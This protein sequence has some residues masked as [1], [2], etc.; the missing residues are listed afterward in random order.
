MARRSVI[1]TQ[2]RLSDGGRGEEASGLGD[3]DVEP[4]DALEAGP[5]W[6]DAALSPVADG[7]LR[8]ADK[9]AELFEQDQVVVVPVVWDADGCHH[10]FAFR[11]GRRRVR[12]RI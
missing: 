11:R 9:V 4:T 6:A 5:L 12:R 3:G 8:C 2:F 1:G 10:L 7:A